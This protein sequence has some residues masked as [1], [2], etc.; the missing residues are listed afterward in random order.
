VSQYT[1]RL[2]RAVGSID[3]PIVWKLLAASSLAGSM[4]KA[5]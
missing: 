1:G 4:S 2:A 3:R 5:F